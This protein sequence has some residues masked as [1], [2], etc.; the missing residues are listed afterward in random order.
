MD[1]GNPRAPTAGTRG[2]VDESCALLTQMLES[3]VDRCNRKGNMVQ[4][5]APAVQETAD[6][7]VG[8][9]RLQQLDE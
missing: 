3:N 4:T 6:R 5:L 9:E 1:K 2:L 7:C 8:A